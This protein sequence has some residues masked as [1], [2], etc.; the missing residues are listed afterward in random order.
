MKKR[1][2]KLCLLNLS[3]AM[4]LATGVTA[5]AANNE[6]TDAR[7]FTISA[8]QGDKHTYEVYQILKGDLAGTAADGSDSGNKLSNIKAGQNAKGLD[9]ETAVNNAVKD[10]VD[11]AKTA[12][13]DS[14]KLAAIEK[15]V[16]LESAAFATVSDGTYHVK[17]SE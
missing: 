12:T 7:T 14:E 17:I 3:A 4:I 8:K 11:T 10:I 6:I 5:F 2:L 9:S 15:Y 16:D 13:T 1:I